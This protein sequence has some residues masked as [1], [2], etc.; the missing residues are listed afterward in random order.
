M[1]GSDQQTLSIH[2]WKHGT[3]AEVILIHMS[4]IFRQIPSR[5]LMAAPSSTR[6]RFTMLFPETLRIPESSTFLL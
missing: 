6:R 2:H 4:K 3:S 5:L 1:L